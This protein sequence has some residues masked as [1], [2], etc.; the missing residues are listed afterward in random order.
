MFF[1]SFVF[2]FVLGHVRLSDL[3]LAVELPPEKDK[4]QGY[5]GTPGQKT[6]SSYNLR[7]GTHQVSCRVFG[8]VSLAS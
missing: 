8:F 6:F 4:T 1:V 3:G 2:C 5:A 7:T